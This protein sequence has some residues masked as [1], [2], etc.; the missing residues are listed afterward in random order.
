[1]FENIGKSRNRINFKNAE[2]KAE[3]PKLPISD[4]CSV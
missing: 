4:K 1:M 2:L 3:V